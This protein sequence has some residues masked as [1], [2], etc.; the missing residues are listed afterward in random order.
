MYGEIYSALCESLLDFFNKDAFAV[1]IWRRDETWLL[2]AVAGGANDLEFGVVAGVAEGVEDVVRLPEGKLRASAADADG[3]LWAI[4][5]GA[6]V[7]TRIRD[8]R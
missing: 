4:V 8:E 6:H 2:H 7:L 5:L 3:I 1:E